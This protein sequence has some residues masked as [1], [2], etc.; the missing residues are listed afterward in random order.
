MEEDD[1]KYYFCFSR[2]GNQEMTGI[3]HMSSRE[4]KEM[5][6]DDEYVKDNAPKGAVFNL[7]LAPVN[8]EL[9]AYEEAKKKLASKEIM[10]NFSF[11]GFK[12][13]EK[14]INDEIEKLERKENKIRF[15]WV[16]KQVI[17][18]ETEVE[19]DKSVKMGVSVFQWPD[20][21]PPESDVT[22]LM[23]DM[24]KGRLYQTSVSFKGDVG[25]ATKTVEESLR[26]I[27]SYRQEVS[28]G[29]D[30]YMFWQ[31]KAE[32][33]MYN[34]RRPG[35]KLQEMK[36]VDHQSAQIH[37]VGKLFNNVKRVEK[38]QPFAGGLVD[39]VEYLNW[40]DEKMYRLERVHP[41][42]EKGNADKIWWKEFFDFKKD[43]SPLSAD[44][45]LKQWDK[46][47]L[48][49]LENSEKEKKTNSRR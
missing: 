2:S 24:D 34:L 48:R 13:I 46:D 36:C 39:K 11:A 38:T 42:G 19:L 49:K 47:Q 28:A 41:A 33:Q 40:K 45:F 10:E 30:N 3:Y 32:E 21:I 29:K 18:K 7:Y 14:V 9:E 37:E 27:V 43:F 44:V 23:R 6:K 12:K 35:E 31:A 4:Y 1:L 5:L 8:T 16:E 22:V 26:E 15:K 25:E 17:V 20:R